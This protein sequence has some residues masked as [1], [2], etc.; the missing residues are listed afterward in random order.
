M[1]WRLL[2][3][4]T[5][6]AVASACSSGAGDDG[7]RPGLELDE[8]GCPTTAPDDLVDVDAETLAGAIRLALG[9]DPP[10]FDVIDSYPAESPAPAGNG[11]AGIPEFQCGPDIADRTVV[12]ETRMTS[13]EQGPSLADVQW[14]VSKVDGE[15]VAWGNY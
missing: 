9:D 3:V 8:R 14:F 5:I 12:V 15:W 6:A 2:A 10:D 1:R 11:F 4:A 7:A 13:T